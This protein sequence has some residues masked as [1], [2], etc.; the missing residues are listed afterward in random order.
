MVQKKKGLEIVLEE[1]REMT[2]AEI[3][4]VTSLLFQWWKRKY[5]AQF[6]DGIQKG[7]HVENEQKN[8]R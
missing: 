1:G 8:K 5:E 2:D 4:T 7:N 6:I 3:E